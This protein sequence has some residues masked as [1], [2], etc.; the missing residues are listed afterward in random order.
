MSE[1]TS[2]CLAMLRAETGCLYG[3]HSV[4]PKNAIWGT[5]ETNRIVDKHL[6]L[7]EAWNQ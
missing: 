4:I 2:A 6:Q 7:M 3:V 5:N 1:A